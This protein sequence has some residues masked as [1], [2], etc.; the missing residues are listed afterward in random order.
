M[1]TAAGKVVVDGDALARTLVRI[2]HEILERNPEP[3]ELCLVGIYTR[4]VALAHRWPVTTLRRAFAGL[5]FA[6]S[7]YMMWKA[8]SLGGA[9]G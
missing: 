2:A 3:D 5:L 4:G 8:A 1:V 6:I 7:G 9:L